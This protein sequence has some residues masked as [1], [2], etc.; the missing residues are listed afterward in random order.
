MS[1]ISFLFIRTVS[2]RPIY[3]SIPDTSLPAS[4]QIRR[5]ELTSRGGATALAFAIELTAES[6][7]W[8]Y[9]PIILCSALIMSGWAL[10]INNLGRRRYPVYWWSAGPPLS[11]SLP[12]VVA[13]RSVSVSRGRRKSDKKIQ[14]D[15]ELGQRTAD[16]QEE[17]RDRARELRTVDGAN[18]TAEDGGRTLEALRQDEAAGRMVG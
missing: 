3:C 18:R 16:Q 14:E 7:S 5:D 15:L 13:P 2:C 12:A 9:I 4:D 6:V 11:V 17:K 1:A 8:R 10:I